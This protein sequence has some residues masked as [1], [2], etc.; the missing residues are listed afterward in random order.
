MERLL[1][2]RSHYRECSMVVK[3]YQFHRSC[4]ARARELKAREEAVRQRERAVAEREAAIGE[5]ER[6]VAAAGASL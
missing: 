2:A 4:A 3:E 1:S 6:R 5:R